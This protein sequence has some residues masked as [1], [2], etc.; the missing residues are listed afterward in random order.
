MLLRCLLAFGGSVTSHFG[1]LSG[2]A[3]RREPEGTVL[4]DEI[5]ITASS[6]S[7]AASL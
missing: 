2:K 5:N 4:G 1:K 7:D 3:G 6:V